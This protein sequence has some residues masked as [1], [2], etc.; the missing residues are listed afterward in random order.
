MQRRGQS[1]QPTKVRRG[2]RKARK[3]PTSHASASDLHGDLDQRTRERDEALEQQ[4]ATAEVLKIISRST[5][6]LQTVFDAIVE[7]ATRLCQASSSVIW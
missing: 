2:G 3:A 6:D 1:G 4:I 5:F 7:S